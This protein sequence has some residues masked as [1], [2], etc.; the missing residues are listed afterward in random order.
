MDRGKP[1]GYFIPFH[2]SLLNPI[3]MLGVD[4]NFCI[5]WWCITIAIGIMLR[6]YW[7][8]IVGVV[9]HMVMREATKADDMFFKVVVNHIQSKKYFW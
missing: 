7:F 1:E 2:Q 5:G 6:M 4:R 9:V 8:L 3:L